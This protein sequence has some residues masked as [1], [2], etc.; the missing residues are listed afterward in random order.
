ML[1]VDQR[2][3]DRDGG[4]DPPSAPR[5]DIMEHLGF[6]VSGTETQDDAHRSSEGVVWRRSVQ[7]FKINLVSFTALK[8]GPTHSVLYRYSPDCKNSTFIQK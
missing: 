5:A 7:L 8:M 2:H 4:G 3:R 1:K 6:T